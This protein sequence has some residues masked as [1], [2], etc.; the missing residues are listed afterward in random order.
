MV[1]ISVDS[2]GTSGLE[3]RLARLNFL[4]QAVVI[5]CKVDQIAF[6]MQALTEL[7]GGPAFGVRA[8]LTSLDAL[9]QETRVTSVLDST[10]VPR[11][12]FQRIILTAAHAQASGSAVHLVDSVPPKGFFR[13]FADHLLVAVDVDV[14]IFG[15]QVL[16][17]PLI[18]SFKQLFVS[19][20]SVHRGLKNRNCLRQ[21]VVL[22]LHVFRAS[23]LHAQRFMTLPELVEVVLFFVF[24][25]AKLDNFFFQVFHSSFCVRES[26]LQV[27]LF[28]FARSQLTFQ[29]AK[30]AFLSDVDSEVS[31]ADFFI[32]VHVILRPHLLD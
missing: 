23:L 3:Q 13:L 15:L 7:R 21:H 24:L 11:F 6:R 8:F 20:H 28:K 9:L 5:R 14:K 26:D 25:R 32:A 17:E 29:R 22:V 30:S 18:F 12:F 1:D 19:F 10:F 4:L 27:T 31:L 2:V 16:F